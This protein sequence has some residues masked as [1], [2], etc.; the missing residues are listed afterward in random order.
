MRPTTDEGGRSDGR[1]AAVLRSRIRARGRYRHSGGSSF[2]WERLTPPCP[3]LM[4][5]RVVPQA[6]GYRF[7]TSD[8]R[9]TPRPHRDTYFSDSTIRSAEATK[10]DPL[11]CDREDTPWLE[12]VRE[13][14]GVLPLPAAAARAG[15]ASP[16][17]AA[18]PAGFC[19]PA[20]VL[21]FPSPARRCHPAAGEG[22]S[23]GR[24]A[25]TGRRTAAQFRFAT[26]LN[27]CSSKFP[28]ERAECA[29]EFLP[30]SSCNDSSILRAETT[31][32]T[33]RLLC[34]SPPGAISI[35][36]AIEP[37]NDT[38]CAALET[39]AFDER[40]DREFRRRHRRSRRRG[41]Q[42]H[43]WR[44]WRKALYAP[45]TSSGAGQGVSRRAPQPCCT[46][47]YSICTADRVAL[48]VEALNAG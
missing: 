39:S 5:T 47:A 45:L 15:D 40:L 26:L 37:H 21:R 11:V 22:T 31:S 6:D 30:T 23:S 42:G 35:R 12:V 43:P 1:D 46:S 9:S 33:L 10:R 18:T 41:G 17:R 48:V 4:R 3:I 27:G 2:K 28:S 34:G 7:F 13:E 16:P 44:I 20:T 14:V 29:R 36:A 38:F 32:A 25:S 24:V 19:H 8:A